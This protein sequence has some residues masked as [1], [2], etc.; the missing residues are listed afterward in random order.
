MHTVDIEYSYD[1]LH[2]VG[3]LAIDDSKPGTRPAIL[4]CHDAGGLDELAKR[5]AVRL[6][7]LGYIALALDYY[8]GGKRLEP[9]EVGERMTAL[10]TDSDAIR[11]IARAGLE[12]LLA[13]E[14]ADPERVAAIGYCFGGSMALELAR[15]GVDLGAVVG[16]H[17]G[18]RTNRPEDSAQIKARVLVCI[19]ADDPI[20][21]PEQR[22]VFEQEMRDAG[23]DWQ[24][25]LY[26]GAVHS[27]TNPAAG[28]ANPALAY[29]RHADESSW[30]A[31]LELFD[32]VF[33]P[34]ASP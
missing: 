23:V 13:D 34:P 4:I 9:A 16:F 30:R 22:L 24:M 10:A 5:T 15:S 3:H 28:T 19:G 31:M 14:C 33:D 20:V 8:G 6:A 1:D 32:E 29:N 2:L 17:S 27:F 26:G 21:P 11:A 7:E 12:A 25:N 18:L